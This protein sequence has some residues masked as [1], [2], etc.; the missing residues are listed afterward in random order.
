[1]VMREYH[2]EDGCPDRFIP[3]RAWNHL[4]KA[5]NIF[6]HMSTLKDHRV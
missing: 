5:I 4:F 6:A 1:M 2:F 3:F